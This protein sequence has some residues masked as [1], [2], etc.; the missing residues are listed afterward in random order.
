MGEEP[1]AAEGE[2]LYLEGG[3]EVG[4][5]GVEGGFGGK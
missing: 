4:E 5:A 1:G 2:P 3:K